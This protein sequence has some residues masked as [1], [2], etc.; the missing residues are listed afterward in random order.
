MYLGCSSAVKRQEIPTHDMMRVNLED[1]VSE[2]SQT[3]ED[4]RCVSSSV[5]HLGGHSHGDQKQHRD[6]GARGRE[7]GEF[8]FPGCGVSVLQ[9]EGF[10]TG[11]TAARVPAEM[12]C[13]FYRN[14]K[15]SGGQPCPWDVSAPTCGSSSP[16]PS[17]CSPPVTPVHGECSA[18]SGPNSTARTAVSSAGCPHQH[19]AWR[20]PA[21]VMPL[22]PRPISPNG[23]SG[24]YFPPTCAV[25]TPVRQQEFLQ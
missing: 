21:K 3:R 2:V 6:C 16:K 24:A 18:P 22:A 25:P 11:C 23:G 4:K 7:K 17:P 9:E 15:H 8:L 12:S 1:L 13:V 14:R 10:P 20:S 5:R 19:T